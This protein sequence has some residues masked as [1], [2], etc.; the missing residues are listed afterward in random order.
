[1]AN[2][3]VSNSPAKFIQTKQLCEGKGIN[4]LVTAMCGWTSVY[5]LLNITG[6]KSEFHFEKIYHCNSGDSEY[7]EKDRVVG[8]YALALLGDTPQPDKEGFKLTDPD[9]VWLLK[10][11]RNTLEKYLS[12]ESTSTFDDNTVPEDVMVPAGAFV[13]LKINGE[14][15]GCIGN[16]SPDLPLYKTVNM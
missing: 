15:R 3:I 10:L 6:D 2:A 13:T 16:F 9:K 7:G 12:T 5:T 4:N 1:M 14:L 11:A 8:Y